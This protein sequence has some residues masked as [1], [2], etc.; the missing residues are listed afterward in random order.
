MIPP[1]VEA[2]NADTTLVTL[3][4]G[5]N[6]IDFSAIVDCFVADLAAGRPTD[7][8]PRLQDAAEQRLAELSTELDAVH[9]GIEG[10]SPEATVIVTGYFPLVDSSGECANA[11][12]ISPADRA[13]VVDLTRAPQRGGGGDR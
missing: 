1:Q 13:W 9:A 3:S 4:I 2:L 6:D 12:T 8:G 11:A 7:C 10:R 5:G